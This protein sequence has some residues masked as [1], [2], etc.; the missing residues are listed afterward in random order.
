MYDNLNSDTENMHCKIRI[1]FVKNKIQCNI[2]NK[3]KI[4]MPIEDIKENTDISMIIH[5]R[6]IKFL[7]KKFYCDCYVSQIKLVE[8]KMY[9][10]PKECLFND[11]DDNN[12]S[13][14]NG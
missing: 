2:F 3:D 8:P 9:T 1:P 14:C 12:P 10:I 7:K 11:E 5:I 6:G 13:G 4:P